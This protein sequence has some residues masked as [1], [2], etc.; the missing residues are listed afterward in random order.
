MSLHMEHL[1][2]TTTHIRR[3]P[4]RHRFRY[5]T[6]FVLIDP[7]SDET[8]PTLFSRNRFNLA[9]VHDT[10]HGGPLKAGRGA[11]WAREVLARAG[12]DRT[13][14]RLALL[15]QP[16][17]L[18]YG[19]NPVSFWFAFEG[20]ALR[21]VIAEVST[22]FDDRHSY[23]CHLPGFADITSRA[24][25]YARKAL[26][27]SPFQ[28][29]AGGYEFIFDI[30]PSRIRVAICHRNGDEGVVATLTG[31]RRPLTNASLLAAFLR[32]PFGALRTITLIHWQALRLKLKGAHYRKR[33]APPA[34][35]VS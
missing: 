13:G 5:G 4:I 21:A 30:R 31:N 1:A 27:V 3:G 11:V 26:H 9:A 6:D 23:L 19:F 15:T 22:P 28:E 7:E 2:G 20:K 14:I 25:I 29:V 35:E 8:G 24:R 18:G 12:L 33:P 16:R 34:H 32:R 17:F 10:D